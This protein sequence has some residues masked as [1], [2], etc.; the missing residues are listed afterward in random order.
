MTKNQQPS[1]ET[2]LQTCAWCNQ[3][4]SAEQETYGFGAKSN[5]KLELQNNE[6]EFVSLKL[7]LTDK[8]IIALVVPEDSPAKDAGYDLLFL[9][10]SEE[11][12]QDLKYALELE[13]D[14]F[15]D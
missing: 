7:S 8:I 9:T 11:C 10:C 14:V 6:G 13:I 5:P 15:S 3:R 12:A 1:Q 2:L 4:L